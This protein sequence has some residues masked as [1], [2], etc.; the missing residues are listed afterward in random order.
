MTHY[1]LVSQN[2]RRSVIIVLLFTAFI[3]GATYLMTIGLGYGLDVVGFALIFSGITSFASYWWSD[4]IILG[5]SG[6]RKATREEF[7]DYYTVTENLVIGS[8]MPMPKLYVIDDTAMNAFAT[9]RDPEHAVVCATTGLLQRLDRSEIEGV[10][11]H[12]L[13]HIQNYDIRLMSI[14]TILVGLVALLS[15]WFLR[16]TFWGG[17]KRDS[18][19]NQGGQ[20][21]VILFVVGI[22]LALL[23]PLIAQLIKLAISRRREFLADASAVAMSKNP[24]GLAKA[25][26]KL[27]QD[28]EPLEAANKA[29]AHLYIADPLKNL[30]SA[31]GMFSG[32]FQT[33]PPIA[34]RI[35]ALRGISAQQL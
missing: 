22:V 10:V 35:S 26:A 7:F 1:Q 16:M 3:A 15:D 31:V 21:K 25:L 27:S 34:D 29:T 20:L 11:A 30:H 19:S 8:R 28:K 17:N 2:K 18:D 24:E 9:G 33:H 5:I 23:S 14:V 4:K 6:A 13:S 32:L 12:E